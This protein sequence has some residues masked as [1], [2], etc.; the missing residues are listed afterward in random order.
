MATAKIAISL[1]SALVDQLDVLVHERKFASRSQLIQ[2]A[3]E[4]KLQ[5]V[6]KTRLSRELA[7]IDP[8]AERHLANERLAAEADLWPEY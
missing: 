3:V 4:E 6:R 5:R 8:K 2:K 1:D 7:K